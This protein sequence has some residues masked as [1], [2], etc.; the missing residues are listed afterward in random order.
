MTLPLV[1]SDKECRFK[2]KVQD[3]LPEGGNLDRCYTCGTCV[4]G[5]PAA[6]L[7]GMDFRKFLRM[8][9]M[10]LDDEVESSPWIWMCTMCA[11]CEIH[12]PMGVRISDLIRQARAARNREDIPGGIQKGLAMALA[13]G[14]NL[15]LPRD[16]FVFIL[17]DVGEELAEEPGFEDFTVPIDREGA[18]ILVTIHNK[19]VNTQNEDL[20]HLW[21]IFHAAGEKWTVSSD[22]W[23]GTSWG[24][25]TGDDEAIKT[26]TGRLVT[27]MEGLK[28][29]KLLCPE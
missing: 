21:K 5:C 17:E 22:D 19:L 7:R 3:S 8:V 24:Y 25:F 1:I 12:C 16:D 20:K 6:R 15:G 9:L 13:T 27:H 28:T 2:E 26:M 23:E 29:G 10:G 11:R 4:S 18:N 14:N